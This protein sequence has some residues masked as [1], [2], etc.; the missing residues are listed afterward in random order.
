[1]TSKAISLGDTLTNRDGTLCRGTQLTFKAPYWIYEDGVAVKN[2]GD[3]KEAA[4]AH[5]DRRVKDRWGDQCRYAC[6]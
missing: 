1:M 5:F 3:D 4:F 6:C 2:Y